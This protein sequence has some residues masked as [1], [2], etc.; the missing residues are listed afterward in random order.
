L[1]PHVRH[2]SKYIDVPVPASR[3]FVFTEKGL[4]NGTRA[5]TLDDL[6]AG[7]A[8]ADR[9]TV[10]G[11][12]R[13]HDFSRW[14]TDVFGD[15]VLGAEIRKMESRSQ[16]ESIVDIRESIIKAIGVRYYTADPA[17]FQTPAAF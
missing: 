14:L 4:P 9:E 16:L 17:A 10:D 7:L 12:L 3:A 6:I 5:E 1:T 8:T 11:H 15:Q 13:R 2:R